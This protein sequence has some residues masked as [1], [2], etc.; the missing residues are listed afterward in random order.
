M[1]GGHGA[2]VKISSE[3]KSLDFGEISRFFKKSE[4]SIH[5]SGKIEKLIIWKRFREESEFSPLLACDRA[6]PVGTCVQAGHSDSDE[7]VTARSCYSCI[8]AAKALDRQPCW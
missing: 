1:F 5:F 4:K 2:S 7:G 8:W 3:Q 6:G